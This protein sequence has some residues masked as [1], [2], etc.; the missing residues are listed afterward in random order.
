MKPIVQYQEVFLPVTVGERAS[1]RPI[2]H[3]SAC[4]SNML[5]VIT[6]VVLAV[7]DTWFETENTIYQLI[8]E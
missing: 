2:N 5:P 7:H 8:A 4:V 1:V 3:P 6:S